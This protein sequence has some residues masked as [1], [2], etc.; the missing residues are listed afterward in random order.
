MEKDQGIISAVLLGAVIM[1]LLF[2]LVILLVL[3]HRRKYLVQQNQLQLIKNEK[4]LE[5][6]KAILNTQETERKRIAQN[7][8]D[9]VGADLSVVQFNLTRYIHELQNTKCN[10]Q[11]LAEEVGALET[12]IQSI[13][14]ICHDLYPLTLKRYGLIERIKQSVQRINESGRI[15]CTYFSS[16]DESQLPFR[17]EEKLNILRV[18]M[19]IMNNIIKHSATQNLKITPSINSNLFMLDF[20]HDGIPFTDSDATNKIMEGNGIGLSSILNRTELM[21]GRISYSNENGFSKI[22]V[23]IPS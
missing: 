17:N 4:E 7:L 15:N 10:I 6:I 9:S 14:D 22:K 13:R 8:H 5:T 3:N 16:I 1:L 11:P 2:V 12:T 20:E 21:G 18:Y 19:E 23:S